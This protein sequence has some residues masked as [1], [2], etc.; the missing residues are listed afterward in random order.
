MPPDLPIEAIA[1]EVQESWQLKVRSCLQ[2]RWS[3]LA[4]P[5]SDK[6]LAALCPDKCHFAFEWTQV[7]LVPG[8]HR[9]CMLT[10]YE[11][12]HVMSLAGHGSRDG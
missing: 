6:K 12:V 8:S 7:L 10:A 11:H 2:H 5:A 4:C 9:I 1:R 3:R